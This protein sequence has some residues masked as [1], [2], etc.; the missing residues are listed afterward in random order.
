EA[1]TG[2]T[3]AAKRARQRTRPPHILMTTPEQLAL[4]ISHPQAEL[5]FGSL[6]RVVLDE[7]HALVTNKRGDL[8]S[9]GLARLAKLAPDMAITALSATVARSDLLRDWIAQPTPNR[10]TD[11][12]RMTGGAPPELAILET[13]E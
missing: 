9:L 3:S 5:M 4:L 11:L 10:Q 1:R 2:D 8:L 13:E 12:L 6:R 7:L